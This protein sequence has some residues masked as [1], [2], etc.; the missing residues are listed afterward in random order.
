MPMQFSSHTIECPQSSI[1]PN[2]V[3]LKMCAKRYTAGGN[4]TADAGSDGLTLLFAHCIGAHKEIWESVIERLFS[5]SGGRVA[6]AWSFDWQTHG[7]SAVVNRETFERSPG[8]AHTGVTA[9]EWAAGVSAFIDGPLAKGKRLVGIGHSAGGGAMVLTNVNRPL[10]SL[11]FVS[12]ILIEPSIIPRE[13]FYQEIE[14]RVSTMEFIVTATESRRERWRS[15]EAAYTWMR[16]RVPWESW[17]E[18]V[19][20]KLTVCRDPLSRFV[21]PLTADLKEHG[22][23][24]PS[25]GGVTTKLDRKLEALGYTDVESHFLAPVELG[26]ICDSVPVHFV[27][28]SECLVPEFVQRALTDG[29]E[30]RKATSVSTVDGGHLIVQENPDGTADAIWKILSTSTLPPTPLGKL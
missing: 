1:D 6:E 25:D 8:R 24:G 14:E 11:P 29:T 26:R 18:R 2:G 27:W 19:L 12:L 21:P 30:G 3:K 16:K 22:L 28:G 5:L 10:R 13:L 4:G 23:E 7:D 17:D 9:A 20:R 15:A